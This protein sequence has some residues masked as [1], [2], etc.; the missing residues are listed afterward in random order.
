MGLIE[1]DYKAVA[2]TELEWRTRQIEERDKKSQTK[3]EYEKDRQEVIGSIKFSQQLQLITATQAEDFLKRVRKE[4]RAF[5]HM[6]RT[7]TR[8]IVDDFENPRERAARY[9][10][11]DEYTAYI[12]QERENKHSKDKGENLS[13]RS[14]LRL[15]Q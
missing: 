8:D 15:N 5:E 3:E 2:V 11:L 4:L 14:H 7:E 9:H 12:A 13:R 1:K 10:T 6:Q